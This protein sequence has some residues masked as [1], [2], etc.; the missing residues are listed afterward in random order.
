VARLHLP[1][2]QQDGRQRQQR[3][4]QQQ[5]S[6]AAFRCSDGQQADQADGDH[7]P[8]DHGRLPGGQRSQLRQVSAQTAE[9]RP[10]AVHPPQGD[11]ES[12]IAPQG[13]I[14]QRDDQAGRPDHADDQ[15]AL[16]P[17][18]QRQAAPRQD[19]DQHG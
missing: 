9:E 4:C 11:A 3:G 12:R 6:L 19:D 13:Q 7:R 16:N 10:G 18:A 8:G 14:Q 5:D 2:Q 17:P 1:G 15:Q